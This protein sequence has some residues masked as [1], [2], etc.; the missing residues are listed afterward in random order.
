MIYTLTLNPAIDY[1]LYVGT[2]SGD[3][4]RRTTSETMRVG[5]KGINVAWADGHATW[6]LK[7]FFNQSQ[8]KEKFWSAGYQ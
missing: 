6:E 8:A 3:G 7:V 4:I 2:P 1:V 5:G